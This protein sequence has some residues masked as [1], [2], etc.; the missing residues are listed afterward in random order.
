[1]IALRILLLVP[2]L[3]LPLGA[4]AVIETYEFETDAL[5]ERYQ[6]LSEELRCPKCQNQNIA[7]SN[8][9]ISQQLREQLHK[10]LHEGKSDEEILDFMVQRYGE[11]VLY[12]PR[13]SA[14]TALLWLAPALLLGLGIGIVAGIMRRGSPVQ[15]ESKLGDEERSRL[16]SLLD[17]EANRD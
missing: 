13:W 5:H 12:R 2:L 16:K 9:P 10:Q 3:L 1:M 8:A 14:S 6:D 17:S 11:F 7:A 4:L 15:S